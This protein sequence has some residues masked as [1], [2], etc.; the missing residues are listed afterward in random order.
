M[1]TAQASAGL[2][3][4]LRW[5]VQTH[6]FRHDLGAVR[7]PIGYYANVIDIGHGT[8]LAI[9]TDG[10]GSKLLV[11]QLMDK[12]DTVGIDCVAMNANDVLCVGARPLSLVDYIAVQT[13]DPRLLEEL[14]KGLYE[15]A[16]QANITIAGGELAQIGEM[17]KGLREGYAFDLAA[18]CVG[19]V[20]LDRVIVGQDIQEGDLLI[21]LASTG[22][23]SNGL[24]LA[25]RVLFEQGGFSVDQYVP[26][27]GRILGEELLAP[28]RIYVPE[29]TT[30]LDAQLP[31]KALLHI[32]GDGFLN[33][34]RVQAGMGLIIEQLP[35][36]PPIFRLIQERGRITDA[37]MYRV[38][39][40]G[41][42]FC[43]VAA[44]AAADQVGAIA[45]QHGVTSYYLGHAVADP[46]RRIWL[47]PKQLVSSGSVFVQVGSDR[48]VGS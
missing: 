31:I 13:A 30:M 34:H 20:P 15:G 2:Q 17:I 27:L 14:G 26:E 18:T 33:L 16:R 22:I 24:T 47:K 21:G 6:A 10:V 44:P 1:D 3:G 25:R 29:I 38:F 12:Y 32:T 5:V 48:H 41:V 23:H 40:M 7:L 46:E 35:D 19:I 11:A 28:T 37:E 9:S 4:L 39:N 36:P 45:R 43:I 8:G 42:G